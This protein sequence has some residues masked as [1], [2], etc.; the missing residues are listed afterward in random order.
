MIKPKDIYLSELILYHY[1]Q[2]IQIERSVLRL[3]SKKQPVSQQN[4]V[5]NI[6]VDS[7]N[8][9]V[10]IISLVH[11]SAVLIIDLLPVAHPQYRKVRMENSITYQE[12][13]FIFIRYAF[14]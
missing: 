5:L 11:H 12:R 7:V 13:T 3:I 8:R 9:I 10:S 6:L 14:S 2:Q 1:V 4:V